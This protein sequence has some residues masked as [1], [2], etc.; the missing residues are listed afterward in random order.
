MV[1]IPLD[2]IWAVVEHNS[3]TGKLFTEDTPQF[4]WNK[5]EFLVNEITVRVKKTVNGQVSDFSVERLNVL[6]VF[7]GITFGENC[8]MSIIGT[9]AVEEN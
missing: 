4:R 6:V 2:N 7:W 8:P 3:K 1:V 5:G 9:G